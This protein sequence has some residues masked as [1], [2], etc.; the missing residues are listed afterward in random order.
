MRDIEKGRE[1]DTE[2]EKE[3]IKDFLKYLFCYLFNFVFFVFLLDLLFLSSLMLGQ[4]QCNIN[5]LTQKLQIIRNLTP[6]SWMLDS[7]ISNPISIISLMID[8]LD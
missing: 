4:T 7:S 6:F 3:N 2:R 5:N 8:I 1:R